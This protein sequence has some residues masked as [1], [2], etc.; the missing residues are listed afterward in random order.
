MRILIVE[1]DQR[2]AVSVQQG[3]EEQGMSVDLAAD[4]DEGLAAALAGTYDVVVLDLLLPGLNG[5]E[6]VRR[7]RGRAV[8]TPVLM[9]T[10]LDGVDDRVQGLESGADDYLSKPFAQRELVARI[11]A[12]ARRHLG[13][14]SAVLVLGPVMM[15]TSAHTLAVSGQPVR[16]TAKE[17]AILEVFMLHPGQVIHREQVL[18]H[19]WNNEFDGGDNLVEV[20]IGRLRRKLMATGIADPFTTIRNAGYRFEPTP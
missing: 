3:L 10:A 17:F 4:G 8:Q 16:L 7:M 2:L 12:L 20:Y 1:D 11:R 18:E 14:R 19:A 13:N 15:D 6:V 5:H 9:L